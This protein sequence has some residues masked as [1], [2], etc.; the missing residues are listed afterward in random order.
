MPPE[1]VHPGADVIPSFFLVLSFPV[2]IVAIY[3]GDIIDVIVA[4]QA[5]LTNI[6]EVGEGEGDNA[7]EGDA[8]Q[9]Q[10]RESCDEK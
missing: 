5:Q 2:K 7:G 4:V 1:G 10:G 6:L 9:V 3:V 8:A